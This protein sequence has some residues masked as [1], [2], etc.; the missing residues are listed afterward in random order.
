MQNI[1][2]CIH[3]YI[4]GMSFL[5]KLL[6]NGGLRMNDHLSVANAACKIPG[7]LLL[8]TVYKNQYLV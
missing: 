7:D 1:F 4:F 8:G 3:I 2:T 5:K 6:K